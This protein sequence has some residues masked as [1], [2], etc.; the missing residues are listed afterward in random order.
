[1]SIRRRWQ[2][3]VVAG[4]GVVVAILAGYHRFIHYRAQRSQLAQAQQL[5]EESHRLA[6]SGDR[7]AAQQRLEAATA[8]Y[9]QLQGRQ[10][11]RVATVLSEQAINLATMRKAEQALPLAQEALDIRSK[12]YGTRHKLVAQSLCD[13]ADQL[14]ELPARQAE[15]E[16]L[17]E[18]AQALF[19]ATGTAST[20][21]A[22]SCQARRGGFAVVRQDYPAAILHLKQAAAQFERL[23]PL[24]AETLGG[25]LTNLTIAQSEA[26]LPREAISSGE[27]AL[28]LLRSVSPTHP[29]LGNTHTALA[30]AFRACG[31]L[32]AAEHHMRAA[33][34][35]ARQVRG[36]DAI[37]IAGHL[38]NLASL[39][40][41]QGAL[42]LAE[43]AYA[44]ARAMQGKSAVAQVS[45]RALLL[46]GHGILLRRLGRT[47]E[48]V[49]ELKEALKLLEQAGQGY[50]YYRAALEL[51]MGASL[52]HLNQF[53]D[54][55]RWLDRS[56]ARFEKINPA[57]D[58]LAAAHQ[59]KGYALRSKGGSEAA[60]AREYEQARDIIEKN[61]PQ[62][63]KL[64]NPLAGL[65]TLALWSGDVP[66]AHAL[67]RRAFLLSE[68]ALNSVLSNIDETRRR[69]LLADLQ[70]DLDV[71]YATLEKAPENL[72][73]RELALSALLLRKGRGLDETRSISAAVYQHGSAKLRGL[74]DQQQKLREDLAAVMLNGNGT[75]AE[76]DER[77]TR[78]TTL[79]KQSQELDEQILGE[80][81][82]LRALKLPALE[83]IVGRVASALPPEGALLEVAYFV[84]RLG[85]DREHPV[86]AAEP[87]YLAFLLTPDRHIQLV[88]LG[89]AAAIDSL[90]REFRHA[91]QR[92]SAEARAL[93]AAI[94]R[95]LLDPLAKPLSTVRRL[96]VSADGAFSALPFYA[97]HDGKQHLVTR[98]QIDHV[99][100]GRD[101]L[102]QHLPSA[103]PTKLVLFAD[104]DMDHAPLSSPS[105][106]GQLALRDARPAPRARLRGITLATLPALPG[107]RQEIQS[108]AALWPHAQVQS[109]TGA[110][111]SEANF[112]RVTGPT[113]LHVATHGTFGGEDEELKERPSRALRR[114][115]SPRALAPIHTSTP[116]LELSSILVFAGARAP[117]EQ[118]AKKPLT[119][120][121]D[122]GTEPSPVGS[123]QSD[124]LVTAM[125]VSGMNLWGT[126]LVVLSACDTGRG[127]TL[128]GQELYGL[129]RAV[130][131]AG[132]ETVVASLWA[133]DDDITRGLMVSFYQQLQTGHGRGESLR[134]AALQ[135]RALHPEPRYWAPFILV[136]QSAPLELGGKEGRRFE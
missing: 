31:R 19:A 84:D 129:Q 105:A 107:T 117:V 82:E 30:S 54:A 62:S 70:G 33:L 24:P 10:S 8:I 125:E 3:R 48:S 114:Q 65:A 40:E 66:Q 63:P 102:R 60:A 9:I 121:A 26:G 15:A 89:A 6:R 51:S 69:E 22:A 74:M 112:L 81:A 73:M 11:D 71:I 72:A 68:R 13:V 79:R 55:L 132:A 41:Q 35:M 108:I 59:S 93:G 118:T 136:G 50:E 96:W 56:I 123:T 98:F 113:I 27:R 111:A 97:L 115:G 77:R 76:R 2:I 134:T 52:T 83:D 37:D 46:A 78:V 75:E 92:K 25:A 18:R 67:F 20:L 127:N 103:S 34:A 58:D 29:S 104:P 86:P 80:S 39:Y 116:H 1:M 122:P 43:A 12:L 32:D 126:Q 16:P 120:A 23:S 91:I 128:R 61:D 85:A 124:G 44:E 94:Y 47:Q 4:A 101:L 17:F 42:E 28:S 21:E 57:S 87:H 110:D 36:I 53:D 99:T 95:R 38:A 88:D 7:E 64:M 131:V 14:M 45:D 100:T 133:A 90:I 5:Q 49:D 135:T 106:L 109:F 119:G 130:L